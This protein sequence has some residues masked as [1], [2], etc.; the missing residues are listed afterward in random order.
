LRFWLEADDKVRLADVIA[1][2]KY[3]PWSDVPSVPLKRLMAVPAARTAILQAYD[4]ALAE[5]PDQ[6][7]SITGERDQAI[8]IGGD[9]KAYIAGIDTLLA[10]KP[11]DAGTLNEAC[12]ARAWLKVDLDAALAQCDKSIAANRQAATLDSRG[13]V[14]LQRSEWDKAAADYGDAV[15]MRPT[16]ASSLYGRGIARKRLGDA[17]GSKADI[18]A[19]TML[20]SKIAD[21]YAVYGIAP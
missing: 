6:A 21:A 19:A 14:R 11:N 17:A 4:A 8:A 9:P 18:A 5:S 1:L 15:A 16:L 20:D 7:D 13:L 2:I 3:E 10:K 12:W